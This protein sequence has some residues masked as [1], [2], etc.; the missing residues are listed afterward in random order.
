MKHFTKKMISLVL[1]FLVA[2]AL[3]PISAQAAPK[4]RLNKG[5]VTIYT[6]NTATLKLKGASGKIRWTIK[7]KKIAAMK[8][9]GSKSVK[10]TAKKA[11]KTSV[12][13]K[14]DGK[15]VK[16]AV[17]VK[18][19]SLNAKSKTLHI[20]GTY[21]LKLTG[22]KIKSCTSSNK[23]VASVTKSGKVTAKK[24]G[25]AVIS[26]KSS[27]Q[28]IYK[29][30][31]IVKGKGQQEEPKKPEEN[32]KDPE[33]GEGT[34]GTP[35]NQPAQENDLAKLKL[36][37]YLASNQYRYTG[38]AIEPKVRVYG[39]GLYLVNGVDYNVSYSDNVN[40]GKAKATITG[41][42]AYKGKITKEFEIMKVSQNIE[43]KLQD[44]T[45][46]VG[47]NGK[48]NI[49]GAYGYVEFNL[50]EE[51][52]AQISSDGTITGLGTGS[53]NIFLTASGDGNHYPCIDQ[54][55]GSLKV[56][57]EEPTAY[58]FEVDSWSEKSTYKVRPMNSRNQDGT[59]TYSLYFTCNSD[60]GWM[61]KNITFE[62]LDVTPAAY[63]KMFADMGVA[64]GEPRVTV[65]S[66][67]QYVDKIHGMGY[68]LT[69]NE[70]FTEDGPGGYS[71]DASS[72]K[73][74][75]VDA[76]AG[77]RVVKLMAK[78]GDDVLDYIYLCTN[79]KEANGNTSSFDLEL[80]QAVRRKVEAQI[81]SDGMSN[82][83]KLQALAE[84]INATTHYPNT[85]ATS[86][87]HNPTFWADWSVDGKGLF[88]NMCS[89]PI[90]NVMVWQGGITTCYAAQD[91]AAAAMEDLGLPY[92]YQSDTGEIA[93]GEGVWLG[94]GS[95][96]STPNN[97]SHMSL[98]YKSAEEKV[99]YLDAQGI[100]CEVRQAPCEV[101]GCREKIVPLK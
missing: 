95:G 27:N 60:E 66:A 36:G 85:D 41:I 91:L 73:R 98:K 20:K 46:Y 68:T 101:H 51:G 45:V 79:A 74:I 69:I 6:G 18:N 88:W 26:V 24:S 30:S 1:A 40:A 94:I 22:A 23:T 50:S 4:L 92:L 59:N 42:G 53:A 3:F 75:Y 48:I 76:G 57:H 63:A 89:D 93:P 2:C 32:P 34:I 21:Q 7:N 52:V 49:S 78:R 84:Y 16:C 99:T 58:G 65:E 29:C 86:K 8:K 44:K 28:K 67:A 56:F 13:A 10:L 39:S 15:S 70:P 19:P 35:E 87:E 47:K 25:K 90:D 55:V 81:W 54:Y 14:A 11:G 62:A 83:E 100:D 96:S 80:E 64:Y 17:T 61:D 5:K 38:K 77:V 37:V 33:E 12:T 9:S 82:L 71:Q 43:A 97:P 72:G 31:I